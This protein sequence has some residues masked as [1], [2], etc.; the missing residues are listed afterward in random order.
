MICISKVS[1]LWWPD[2]AHSLFLK[3]SDLCY[4]EIKRENLHDFYTEVIFESDDEVCNFYWA[5]EI[6]VYPIG[7]TNVTT[8]YVFMF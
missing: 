5:K 3:Q 8:R 1:Q 4:G 2:Q 7:A 6:H